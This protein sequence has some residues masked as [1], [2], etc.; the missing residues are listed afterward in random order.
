MTDART[1]ET[2]ES[3]PFGFWIDVGRGV[4]NYAPEVLV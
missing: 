2:V 1:Y 3:L 4:E